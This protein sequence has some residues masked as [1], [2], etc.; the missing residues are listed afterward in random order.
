[1]KAADDIREQLKQI[2]VKKGLKLLSTDFNHPSYY[3]NI[4]KCLLSGYFMQ[5]LINIQTQYF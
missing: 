3:D 5:V 4:K 1:M 2:M